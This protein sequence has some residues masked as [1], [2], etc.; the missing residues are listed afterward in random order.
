[1]TVGFESFREGERHAR[2]S[3]EDGG[4]ASPLASP[5]LIAAEDAMLSNGGLSSLEQLWFLARW[6]V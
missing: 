6:A 1:M 4:I 5:V 3:G 2:P